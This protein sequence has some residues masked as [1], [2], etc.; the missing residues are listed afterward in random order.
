M[1]RK[2]FTPI[3]KVNILSSVLVEILGGI[4]KVNP[5]NCEY[6][7]GRATSTLILTAVTQKRWF[8][9]RIK[10][11]QNL[12]GR[13]SLVKTKCNSQ[14]GLSLVFVNAVNMGA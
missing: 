1:H 2:T 4:G 6:H 5:P 11:C 14:P 8:H 7:A 13:N 12:R 9:K 10:I 3:S